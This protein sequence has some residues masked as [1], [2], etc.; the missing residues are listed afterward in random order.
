MSSLTFYLPVISQF[1][2]AAISFVIVCKELN[3]EQTAQINLL[4]YYFFM[5]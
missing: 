5:G 1:L 3:I 4:F 2:I